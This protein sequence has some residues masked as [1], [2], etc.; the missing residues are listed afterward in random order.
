MEAFVRHPVAPAV[1]PLGLLATYRA[2][3]SRDGSSGIAA[4]AVGGAFAGLLAGRIVDPP[5][6]QT[7]GALG[8]T[9]AALAAT[10][11][12]IRSAGVG[13]FAPWLRG[14]GVRLALGGGLAAVA[15][16]WLLADLGVYAGD[17]PGL[18]RVFLSRQKLPPGASAPAVHLG[19]HH[20]LDG[21]LLA[22]TGLALSRQVPAVPSQPARGTLGWILSGMT[23]YGLA[24]AAE[25]AWYE[26]VVKRGWTRRRLP[27][28]V[29]DGRSESPG[30]WAA[31]L[32]LTAAVRF[33]AASREPAADARSLKPGEP[34]L[35]RQGVAANS[36]TDRSSPKKWRRAASS[37]T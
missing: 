12:A 6:G 19:H 7:A 34:V 13:G 2:A 16:P 31:L 30:A 23:L 28:L 33:A 36:G 10:T 17:V 14:D 29:A 26:Q 37:G 27:S 20:G 5:R 25:D 4:A 9:V 32:G 22:W 8:V 15:L 21:A 1:V 35:S 11:A 24:R 3:P 18:R